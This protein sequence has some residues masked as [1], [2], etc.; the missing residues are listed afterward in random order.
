VPAA[1][2]VIDYPESGFARAIAALDRQIATASWQ[3]PKVLMVTSP[4]A[5]GSKTT[6]ALS[7]AR[8]AAQRGQRV[9][10]I[11]GDA[12]WPAA[13][14]MMRIREV[15]GG[16]AEVVTGMSRL[17]RSILRD[18]KSEVMLLSWQRKPQ[19]LRELLL[20]RR[21]QQLMIH[22]RSIA[23]LIVIAAPPVSEAEGAAYLTFADGVLMVAAADERAQPAMLHALA[24]LQ[25]LRA[26]TTGVA[27]V[28]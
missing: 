28:G 1:D 5:G 21:M 8:A 26:P 6:I 23:D 9:I 27:L 17:S 18:P 7:L 2:Y 3:A 15:D 11:E 13:A 4:E 19:R 25:A 16:I 12:L 20:S 14:A 24:T 22:L 10:L